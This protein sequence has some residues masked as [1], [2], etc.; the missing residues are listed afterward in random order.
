MARPEPTPRQVLAGWVLYTLEQIAELTTNMQAG[1]STVIAEREL[2]KA[3]KNLAETLSLLTR[4]GRRPI[5]DQ[6]E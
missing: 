6:W 2:R 4:G 5:I 1:E 3:S